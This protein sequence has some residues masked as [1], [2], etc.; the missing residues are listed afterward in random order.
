MDEK[1]RVSSQIPIKNRKNQTI[2]NA[3]QTLI[4]PFFSNGQNDFILWCC[5]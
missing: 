4:D 1:D 5:H 3:N 2:K